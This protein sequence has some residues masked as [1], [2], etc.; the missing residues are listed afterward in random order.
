MISFFGIGRSLEFALNGDDWLALWRYIKDFTTFQSHFDIRNYSNDYSNYAFANIIMGLVYRVFSFNPFPYYLISLFLRIITAL[1]FYFAVY[2][3]TKSKWA[4][5]LSTIFFA[6]MFAGIETTNWVFNMN[7]YLALTVFN[8]FIYFHL[9]IEYKK[10][11]KI[12]VAMA[13]LVLGC[14]FIAPTR[15]HGLLLILPLICLLKIKHLRKEGFDF[16]VRL[17][18]FY[19]PIFVVRFITRAANDKGYFESFAQVREEKIDFFVNLFSS[20]GNS[21]VLDKTFINLFPSN[22]TRAIIVACFYFIITAFFYKNRV[23]FPKLVRFGLFSL[24]VTFSFMLVPH[25]IN[26]LVALPTDHRYQTIPG[27]YMLVTLAILYTILWQYKN[28]FL[29]FLIITISVLVI[30]I[31]FFTLRDYFTI[32]A[33]EGRLQKDVD[34]HFIYL[35][36]QIE[37]PENRTPLAF[38]F[39]PDDAL[40]LYNVI[41]FGL[42]YHIILVDKR[43]SMDIQEAPF[44]TDN[45]KSLVDVLSGKESKELRRYGYNP[46]EIP[47]ENVYAFSLQNKNLINI[48][49]EVRNYLKENL[50]HLNKI[51]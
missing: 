46:I 32:L 45:M 10:L 14:F 16:I 43:F 31:N 50:P 11:S 39:I 17:S 51:E 21:L 18:I 42:P 15:M 25:L 37:K 3:A 4:G 9:K 36:S 1:S 20:L 40:Y 26:P 7:T 47:L 2:S 8:I 6:T 33:R 28:S 24:A 27:S 35:L 48:T 34:N 30:S 13:L 44:L 49:P 38:L 5:Y 29:R 41:A 12:T 19:L 22:L 23:R